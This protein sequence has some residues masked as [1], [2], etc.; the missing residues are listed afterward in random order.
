[1]ASPPTNLSFQTFSENT[2]LNLRY[3]FSY[4]N[5]GNVT[6]N[7]HNNNAMQLSLL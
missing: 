2:L 1:M 5:T 4:Y 6:C 3:E 7:E